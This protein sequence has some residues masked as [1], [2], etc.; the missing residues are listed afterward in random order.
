MNQALRMCEAQQAEVD[1]SEVSCMSWDR[2]EDRWINRMSDR[3]RDHH[4]QSLKSYPH[5][6]VPQ[7]P[8]V[9][10]MIIQESVTD[11]D[12]DPQL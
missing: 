3:V 10:P 7:G 6:Q 1:A 12:E 8:R 9:Q 2:V 11:P 5:T 4:N